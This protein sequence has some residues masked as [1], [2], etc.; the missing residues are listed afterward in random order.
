MVMDI[1]KCVKERNKLFLPAVLVIANIAY[2]VYYEIVSLY[3]VS[4][5]GNIADLSS[6]DRNIWMNWV[7]RFG[8]VRID[9]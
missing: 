3:G 2:N 9:L 4:K 6:T 5:L 1:R 7:I 8:E